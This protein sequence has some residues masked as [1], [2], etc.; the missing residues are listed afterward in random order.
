M[1]LIQLCAR[2]WLL[3][4]TLIFVHSSTGNFD[5]S[6]FKSLRPTGSGMQHCPCCDH[7]KDIY[8]WDLKSKTFPTHPPGLIM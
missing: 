1:R 3:S 5:F 8:K 4:F 6:V 2:H 7:H